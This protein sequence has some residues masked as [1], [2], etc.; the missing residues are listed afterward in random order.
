MM[1]TKFQLVNL[2][3]LLKNFQIVLQRRKVKEK[4]F[5]K[6][7]GGDLGWFGRGKMVGEFQDVAFSTQPGDVSKP[8]KTVHGYHII[9]VEGRRN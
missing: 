5:L 3:N 7:K 2:V 8:F 4:K 9:L 1:E 6:V